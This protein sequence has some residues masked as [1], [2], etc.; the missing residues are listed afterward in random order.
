MTFI[1]T[2]TFFKSV[3]SV[4][5]F[6]VVSIATVCDRKSTSFNVTEVNEVFQVVPAVTFI[7]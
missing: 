3:I 1:K 5:L 4:K 6:F 7:V 2:I